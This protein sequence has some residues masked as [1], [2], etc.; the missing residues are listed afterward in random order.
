MSPAT[1]PRRP[2]DLIFC[3]RYGNSVDARRREA[4][5]KTSAGKRALKL[6]LRETLKDSV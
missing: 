5:L 6:M 3:E 4:Y 1:A 2:F